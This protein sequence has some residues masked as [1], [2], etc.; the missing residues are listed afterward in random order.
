M[1]GVIVLDASVL[2]A[3]LDG[4]DVHHIRAEALLAQE[5]DDDF[6]ASLWTLAEVFVMPV[7]QQ[8]LDAAREALGELDVQEL[9]FP[10]DLAV[11]LAQLRASTN[12]KMP[13]CYVLLAAEEAGARVASFDD[14]LNDEAVSRGLGTAPG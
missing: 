1:A 11:R 14:R 2:I 4:E 10:P 6:A 7:R 13:D 8:R 12:L 5:I 3:F 9:A